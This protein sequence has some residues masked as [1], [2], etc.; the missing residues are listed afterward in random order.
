[1]STTKRDLVLKI[2]SE[3]G[4]RQSDVTKIVQLILDSLADEIVAG[5]TVELRNFGIFEMVT[6]QAR[7]GRNPNNP[8]KDMIIPARNVVKFRAGKELKKRVEKLKP[9]DI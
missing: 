9:N 2:Y 7:I 8:K 5:R 4:M 6:H 1:M 3:T